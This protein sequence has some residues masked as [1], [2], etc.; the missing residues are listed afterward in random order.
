M[1]E[2]AEI[3]PAKSSESASGRSPRFWGLV[4]LSFIVGGFAMAKKKRRG[5]PTKSVARA[6]NQTGNP[7]V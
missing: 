2:I 3:K 7:K 1:N 5:L 6:T 4:A